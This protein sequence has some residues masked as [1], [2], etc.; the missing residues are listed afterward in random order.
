[1]NAVS[2]DGLALRYASLELRGD[3]EIVMMAV[4]QN[5]RALQHASLDLRGRC[6][7]EMIKSINRQKG[8][9]HP[10]RLLL[11]DVYTL[12]SEFLCSGT[13]NDSTYI[14]IMIIF[15]WTLGSQLHR[16]SVTQGLLAGII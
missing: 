3:H 7:I 12:I 15:I 8:F 11:Q 16:T 10:K 4:S 13:P 1:M 14:I 9:K 5:G 2:K 6:R